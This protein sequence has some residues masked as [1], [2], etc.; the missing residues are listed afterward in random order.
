MFWINGSNASVDRIQNG[1]NAAQ[2]LCIEHDINPHKAWL[3]NK[4]KKRGEPYNKHLA[5]AWTQCRDVCL[6]TVYG[7]AV[8]WDHKAKFIFR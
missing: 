6:N 2:I 4:A 1:V 7:E 8:C 3:A 5:A